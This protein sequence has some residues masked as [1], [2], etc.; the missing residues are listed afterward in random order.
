MR[1]LIAPTAY[2][3]TLSPIEAAETIAQAV[4]PHPQLLSHGVGE[5]SRSDKGTAIEF[6]NPVNALDF[7]NLTPL[8]P[9]STRGEGG[10]PAPDAVCSPSPFTER[11]LG[12]EGAKAEENET[13]APQ[14]KVE[15]CTLIR[16]RPRGEGLL[17]ICP[18]ADG[19]TGWLEVWAYHFPQAQRVPTPV[20]DALM[21]PRTAE[22]LLLPNGAAV[23]ESA[24]AIGI[25]M[26]RSEELAPL[27]ATSYGVGELLRAA[28][29]HPDTRALWLG[30][31]G[32]ATTDGGSG[33][34]TALGFQLHDASGEPILQG[35]QGL[36]RLH[37]ILPP[38]A[39]PLMGKPL[40]LCA[41]VQ[42]T[43]L[44]AARVYGPQKGATPPQV[45]QLVQ[46]LER[47]AAV[48]LR[49]RGADLLHTLGAG[50]AGGLA[51]GLHAYL[52]PPIVS[53][54]AW[55]L[56]HIGWD[57]RLAQADCLITGEGQVD[58][59]TLMG[60]GVGVLIQHAVAL[61]KPVLVLAG[62]KGAGWEAVANLPGVRVF[63]CAEIAPHLPPAEALR[64]TATIALQAGTIE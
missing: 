60:K 12:G 15:P 64:E 45:E 21:R 37:T 33:A 58:A 2:K 27:Q 55:L 16:S 11:G 7:S 63:A 8:F 9:L 10:T 26:L 50:A 61:G 4:S 36:A 29:Q 47:L 31:G 49:E 62:R 52:N 56:K 3:G 59:Q 42:N 48:A 34:L 54:I 22:W 46:G 5:G 53:G 14:N 44:D 24:S 28:A 20:H 40:T 1:L 30:L 13:D 23:I 41:D 51:G 17:D 25:H 43:L 39:D 19:G 18:I 57:M 35:G 38:D 32:V 6:S